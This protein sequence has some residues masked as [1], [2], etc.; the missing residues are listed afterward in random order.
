MPCGAGVLLTFG[1]LDTMTGQVARGQ[2]ASAPGP[3]AWKGNGRRGGGGAALPSTWGPACGGAS[4][5]RQS[6][7]PAALCLRETLDAEDSAAADA[8]AAIPGDVA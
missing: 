1:Y 3:A 8:I 6:K 2:A 5:L 7:M 4:G